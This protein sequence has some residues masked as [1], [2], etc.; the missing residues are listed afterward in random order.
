MG[1]CDAF[2]S[3][4][5]FQYQ[6]IELNFSLTNS[7]IVRSISEPNLGSNTSHN[8]IQTYNAW[9]GKY[10]IWMLEKNGLHIVKLQTLLFTSDWSQCSF[11][12]ATKCTTKNLWMLLDSFSRAL[13]FKR[14]SFPGRIYISWYIVLGAYPTYIIHTSDFG[15]CV[16]HTSG[17]EDVK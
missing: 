12:V 4:N 3:N 13:I 1:L 15:Q 5:L 14:S 8:W 6:G 2:V 9:Y 11:K 10:F 16:P 17:A 7:N